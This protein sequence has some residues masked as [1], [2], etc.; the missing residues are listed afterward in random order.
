MQTGSSDV[1]CVQNVFI[2]NKTVFQL[3]KKTWDMIRSYFRESWK[4]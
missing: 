4:Y 2:L 3:Y 1:L